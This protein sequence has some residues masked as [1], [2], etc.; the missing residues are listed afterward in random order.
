M[1]LI[2]VLFKILVFGLLFLAA[3]CQENYNRNRKE[4][5]NWREDLTYTP[6]MMVMFTPTSRRSEVPDT[7]NA[8]TR[9]FLDEK[10]H[11]ICPVIIV[12]SY[13]HDTTAEITRPLKKGEG[14]IGGD[15]ENPKYVKKQLNKMLETAT[16]PGVFHTPHPVDLAKL[17]QWD[18]RINKG[19]KDACFILYSTNPADTTAQANTPEALAALIMQKMDEGF[20]G[21]IVLYNKPSLSREQKDLLVAE[22][23]AQEN[24]KAASIADQ[25]ERMKRLDEIEHFIESQVTKSPQVVEYWY[26]RAINRTMAGKWNSALSSLQNAAKNAINADS[27]MTLMHKI[28]LES[29]TRFKLLK[30]ERTPAFQ[31]ILNGLSENDP[32]LLTI[33]MKILH[34]LNN[35]EAYLYL[36]YDN[37]VYHNAG[38]GYQITFHGKTD[39]YV[40]LSIALPEDP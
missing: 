17:D 40:S 18:Q 37:Q 6:I 10:N 38:K 28:E 34:P 2:I 25:G 35:G 31:A 16:L 27:A 21:F 29:G 15:I 30:K 33:E 24:E 22:N 32:E 12:K 3:S 36:D 19:E 7:I 26:E 9:T 5:S 4:S 20:K 39:D 14:G 1:R 13:L 23:I 8:I 11:G